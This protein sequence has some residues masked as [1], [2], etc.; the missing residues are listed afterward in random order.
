MIKYLKYLFNG[1]I[2]KIGQDWDKMAPS[3]NDTDIFAERVIDNSGNYQG[4]DYEISNSR[5]NMLRDVIA[6]R[7]DFLPDNEIPKMIEMV[8]SFTCKEDIVLYRWV[9]HESFVNTKV[10]AGF[11][12][13]VVF[14]DPGFTFCSFSKKGYDFMP[15]YIHFRIFVPAG[16]HVYPT[17]IR[18]PK[19]REAVSTNE[20][21]IANGAKMKL[22]SID[23]NYWNVVLLSTQ[24]TTIYNEIMS[25]CR[26]SFR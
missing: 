22:V 7:S 23:Q 13:D 4:Y 9:N 8:S 20:V 21:I 16:S 6:G 2:K 1:H 15:A 19:K 3:K 26:I 10:D 17:F 14:Y 11:M 25:A 18:V 5:N 12:N 24:G